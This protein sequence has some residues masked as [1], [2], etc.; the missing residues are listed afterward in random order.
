MALAGGVSLKARSTVAGY[1]FATEGGIKSRPT[2]IA[3]PFDA[4]ATGTVLRRTGS[5]V[6]LLKRLDDADSRRRHD[7]R[8]DQAAR[9]STTTARQKVGYTDAE[10][11][12][13]RSKR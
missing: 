8:R 13:V 3:A 1:F 12:R 10:R 9:R 11:S 4:K 2:A 7:S 5:A 6:V